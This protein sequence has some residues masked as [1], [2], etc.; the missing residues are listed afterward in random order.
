MAALAGGLDLA[1]SLRTVVD[2]KTLLMTPESVQSVADIGRAAR[3]EP[4]PGTASETS[5]CDGNS[6]AL[7][8]RQRVHGHTALALL[9]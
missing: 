5:G 7:S 8:R 3:A 9:H 4:D 6:A 1:L 2:S